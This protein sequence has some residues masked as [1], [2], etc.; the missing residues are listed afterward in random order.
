M[1]TQFVIEMK[2]EQI[3]KKEFNHFSSYLISE[4]VHYQKKKQQLIFIQFI[5]Y[6]HLV[7]L[8]FVCSN[9][10]KIAF[11]FHLSIILIFLIMCNLLFINLILKFPVT[12]DLLF[13]YF[14]LNYFIKKFK[15]IKILIPYFYSKYYL[16]LFFS[17]KHY[18]D[19]IIIKNFQP[20]TF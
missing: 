1:V 3:I 7:Q 5:N 19:S 10:I 11:D 17:K 12:Y 15:Q 2:M 14:K 9:S 16:R 20:T 4:S 8:G 6:F 13:N 18:F